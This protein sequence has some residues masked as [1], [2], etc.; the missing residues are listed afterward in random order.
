[1]LDQYTGHDLTGVALQFAIHLTLQCYTC[2]SIISCTNI[3]PSCCVCCVCYTSVGILKLLQFSSVE[4]GSLSD[5]DSVV[6]ISSVF[7]VR[8]GVTGAASTP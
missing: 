6:Y 7:T 4:V 1:M 5:P 8:C 2:I 3:G